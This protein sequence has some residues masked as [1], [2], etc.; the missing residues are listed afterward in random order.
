[1]NEKMRTAL[2]ATRR[3]FLSG[4]GIGLANMFLAEAQEAKLPV[5]KAKSVIFL[6]MAG[7]PSQLELFD[8]KPELVKY[9]GKPCPDELLKGKRFA[10]IKGVPKMLGTPYKFKQHGQSGA[11]VSELMP[12]FSKIVDDVTIV[13]S[14]S[15]DQFNHAP[16][17]LFLHTGNP[18]FGFASMGHELLWL[19]PP[20]TGHALRAAQW[21]VRGHFLRRH[22]YQGH[23]PPP[24]TP[25]GRIVATIQLTH[26][27]PDSLCG[28][29][30]VGEGG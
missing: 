24:Y 22:C 23:S 4:C 12:E 19:V 14:M 10:F 17:Q 16:A 9:N 1:M 21:N 26:P 5:A 27:R 3:H 15:T 18:R 7:S 11:W 2:A 30:V 6:H 25:Q 8:Y 13:R 29:R 20:T 28:P